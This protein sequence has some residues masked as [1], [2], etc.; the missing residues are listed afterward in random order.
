MVRSIWLVVG[1][2]LLAACGTP[3][4]PS[5]HMDGWT[6]LP[7]SHATFF[8][9]YARGDARMI[10]VLGHGGDVDTIGRYHVGPVDGDADPRWTLLPAVPA[11]WVLGSTT[12]VPFLR[13]LE[14]TTAIVGCAH[15]G[16]VRDHGFAARVREGGVQ[17]IANG[18][19]ID[20]ERVLS[21]DAD[22]FTAYPFGGGQGDLLQRAGIPVVKVSEYLEEHPLGR[23]EWIRFFGMLLGREHEADS[24]FA[25]I[26]VRYEE[27]RVQETLPE[28]PLVL[29]GSVWNGQWWVPPGNSHMARLIADAGGRYA[30]ADRRGRENIAVDMETLIAMGDSID[31]WGMVADISG[32]PRVEDMTQGDARIDALK[33]VR[34]G[35]LFVGNARTADL[36]GMALLEPDVMLA[37]MRVILHPPD[38]VLRSGGAR[39]FNRIGDPPPVPVIPGA[40]ESVQ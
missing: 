8:H 3:K 34:E 35:W 37:D 22:V 11:R 18:D 13:E 30:F 7:N 26:R 23:A 31:A 15:A 24:L 16:Q 2:W 6:L 29:F 21:L 19:G 27:Q 14:A 5:V 12:H 38:C 28:R 33:A 25:G 40:E 17:E 39:Y 4:R 36:F 20:R 9:A 1:A 32:T 10:F